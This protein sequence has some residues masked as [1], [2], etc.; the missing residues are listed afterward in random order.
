MLDVF[1]K[2]T[3]L[4]DFV[5][6]FLRRSSQLGLA[7][8]LR[9]QLWVV[10]D[11]GLGA[12]FLDKRAFGLAQLF[13]HRRI[14]GAHRHVVA[15]RSAVA[16]G[17]VMRRALGALLHVLAHLARLGAFRGAHFHALFVRAVVLDELLAHHMAAR[18]VAEAARFGARVAAAVG[19]DRRGQQQGG[20]EGEQHVNS[21]GGHVSYVARC[22]DSADVCS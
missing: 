15:V 4:H 13:A 20:D 22:A 14:H 3:V 12:R 7:L 1:H 16:V 21:E 9:T 8:E 6:G 5:D 11:A 2:L 17:E 18:L 19:S 10:V